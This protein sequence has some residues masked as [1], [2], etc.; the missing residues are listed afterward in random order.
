MARALRIQ[1]P[2]GRYHATARGN[3]RKAIY[4]EES[5]RTHFLE[6][7]GELT[8]RFGLQVHPYVLM[9]NHLQLLLETPEA[10]L[11]RAMQW[12]NVSYGVWFNRRH[13]RVGHLFQGRFKAVVVEDQAGWF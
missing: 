5:D 4:R 13:D 11:S 6:L 12:L 10:N 9:D 3:D 8:E 2:G 1:R 7:L